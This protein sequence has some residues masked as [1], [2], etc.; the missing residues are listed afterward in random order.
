[1]DLVALLPWW[2]G[3]GLALVSY[4]VFHALANRPPPVVDPHRV[5]AA[6]PAMFITGISG[7]LQLIAPVLCLFGA[8]G[9][10]LRRRKRQNLLSAATVSPSADVL[11]G[12]SWQEFEQLVGEG[13]R[14]QGFEVREQGGQ[15]PDGGV[16]L[17]LRRGGETF[18]VQCKQWRAFK[19]GVDVVRELYG[20][21]AARGAAGGFVVT[22]GQFT[23][24]ARAFAEGR[25]VRLVD[26][27]KLI[28]MLQ[29]ARASLNGSARKDPWLESRPQASGVGSPPC[30]VC[31]SPMVQ[32]TA[33]KGTNAGSL[34]WGCAR[35]PACRGTR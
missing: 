31:S 20:V 18:L 24:D 21:M 33:K 28:G 12:V 32:R 11:N 7:P 9:S 2:L 35:F 26:G 4:L 25:N 16:D 27:G 5:G 17:V 19:V 10:F 14:L 8:L 22:S 1:M 3:V 13:F 30:P 15:G 23:D 34:F 29:Q 6:L